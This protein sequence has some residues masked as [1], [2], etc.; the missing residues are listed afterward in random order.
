[1]E[2]PKILMVCLGNIC[3][4]PLAQ[5]I[6]KNKVSSNIIVDSAGT[7][8]YHIGNSPDPRSILIGEQNG[9]NISHY[10]AR[11]FTKK[12]FNNFSHIYVM[13]KS[14]YADVLTLTNSQEDKEKVNLIHP[15]DQEIPDPYYGNYEAFDKCYLLLN[16]S[17]E[18][19]VKDLSLW[20]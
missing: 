13:D 8:G 12:D 17:C 1:M 7:A 19:I 5:G 20:T 16:Y 15:F 2:T 10:L 6:L 9:I 4:S 11:K 18:Q 3:R 14:N